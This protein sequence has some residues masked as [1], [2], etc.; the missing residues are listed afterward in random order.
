MVGGFL[1]HPATE[2]WVRM[3][4]ARYVGSPVK[5]VEFGGR[6][7]NGSNRQHFPGQEY[8][9]VDKVDGPEVDIVANV[10]DAEALADHEDT[11]DVVV[12]TNMLEHEPRWQDVLTRAWWLLRADGLLVVATVTDPFPPHSGVDGETLREGEHYAGVPMSK[13]L[14]ALT[15][16]GF[17]VEAQ[18]T[19]REG[20]V[21]VVAR[22]DATG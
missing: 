21:Q 10:L 15:A 1:M 20:D 18:A 13:L 2:Q 19:T 8:V 9:S 7:V 5:V 16:I 14:G 4:A 3:A 12:C 22:K 17:D 6:N 11:A